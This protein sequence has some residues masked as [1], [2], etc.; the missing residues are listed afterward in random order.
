MLSIKDR[1]L[2][3]VNKL[4]AYQSPMKLI[5]IVVITTI[6]TITEYLKNSLLQKF[7]KYPI[8]CD[9]WGQLEN[10]YGSLNFN[11]KKK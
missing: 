3:N 2:V 5:V 7:I 8:I 10:L 4:K 11:R 1:A 9:G 6:I